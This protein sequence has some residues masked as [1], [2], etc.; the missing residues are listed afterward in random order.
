MWVFSHIL[1]PWLPLR[2]TYIQVRY[3][4]S[5][6]I[7]RHV[8]WKLS[9]FRE[10]ILPPSS[11]PISWLHRILKWKEYDSPKTSTT[12][13]LLHGDISQKT[14]ISSTMLKNSKLSTVTIMLYNYTYVRIHCH[15]GF[16]WKKPA[17]IRHIRKRLPFNIHTGECGI[18]TINSNCLAKYLPSV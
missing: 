15:I 7:W 5:L 11:V 6:W 13:Y 16:V 17:I 4:K 2:Q 18:I 14:C 3:F 10:S 1:Y 8:Y 9:Y 12:I